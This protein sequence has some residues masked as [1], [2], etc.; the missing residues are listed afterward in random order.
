MAYITPVYYNGTDSAHE[1]M[2]TGDQLQ[3]DLIPVSITGGN[4]IQNFADGL[5]VGAQSGIIYYV[6][7]SGT[8]TT[9]SGTKVAPFQ[10]LDYAL[11]RASVLSPASQFTSNVTIALAAG[12][13]FTMVNDFNIYGGS[14]QI[15]FYGDTNYGDFNSPAIGTGAFPGVM[16]NLNRPIITP[17]ASTTSPWR[18]AGIN[19]YAGNVIFT[20]VQINL[21][22]APSAPSISLY[23]NFVDMVRN[24][25]Y[26]KPGYIELTGSNV[27]M[28]DIAS[29][30]GFMGI[31]ARS[32]S[33]Q[34]V[35]Y[36]SQ[37]LINGTQ[38]SAANSPTSAQLV[39]RQ[40]FAKFFMDFA[41][42]NQQQIY[43]SATSTNSTTASGT[44]LVNWADTEALV[45]GTGETNQAS[46]PI[47]F[48]P[49]YG[50]R[51]YVYNLNIDQQSNPINFISS[52]LI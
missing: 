4:L 29:Y 28:T 39:A 25:A 21:P 1:P 18:M 50:L 46:Y 14:I 31:D 5:Y 49:T 52:R 19:R 9:T 22:V 45:V 43:M 48:D 6:N 32:V 26:S 7:S 38:M 27:N 8:N 40:Y 23:G 2:A 44:L 17:V 41:G 15:A 20:G 16:S 10:T 42:N 35:Q 13:T 34:F 33:S 37:F 36:A 51:N 12:Q 47:A 3:P 11:S 30:W 24:P